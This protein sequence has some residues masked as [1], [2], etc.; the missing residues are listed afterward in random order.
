[1]AN[2]YNAGM[3]SH[4]RMR[5]PM[6]T[7]GSYMSCRARTVESVCAARPKGLMLLKPG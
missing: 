4:V 3:S 1:M 6:V 2:R 7:I 5:H